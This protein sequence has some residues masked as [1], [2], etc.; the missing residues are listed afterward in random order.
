[1]I[2]FPALV[3]RTVPT[4]AVRGLGNPRFFRSRFDS[5]V[6]C[7]GGV[8]SRGGVGSG[9]KEDSS[10][11]ELI[12][13]GEPGIDIVRGG[14][15]ASNSS[16]STRL[17]D[18]FDSMPTGAVPLTRFATDCELSEDADDSSNVRFGDR[19]DR[20]GSDEEVGKGYGRGMGIRM[21][22]TDI[23]SSTS[24]KGDGER[25]AGKGICD[26][27]VDTGGSRSSVTGGLDAAELRLSSALVLPF[28]GG[29]ENDLE[30]G[31]LFV[32][33]CTTVAS[34]SS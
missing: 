18:N 7:D 6:A 34:S 23:E 19:Y 31:R 32:D 29:L 12:D 24:G 25:E 9:D 17:V 2:I 21:G 27:V 26:G 11:N 16:A 1:M 30:E 13:D 28:A 8:S 14:V 22:E 20:G 5:G 10:D 33:L 4:L 15:S 3:A